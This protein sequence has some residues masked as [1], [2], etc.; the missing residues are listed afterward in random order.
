MSVIYKQCER[1][2]DKLFSQAYPDKSVVMLSV[3][4]DMTIDRL[5]MIIDRLDMII[6]VDFDVKRNISLN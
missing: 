2:T 1:S 3:R 5:D 6:A 4:L